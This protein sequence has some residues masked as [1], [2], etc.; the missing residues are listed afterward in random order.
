MQKQ[1]FVQ[2]NGQEVQQS[3]L[4]LLGENSALADDRTL[5]G[6]LRLFPY[7]GGVT[8]KA[9]VPVDFA[10]LVSPAVGVGSVF[11]SP[12]LAVIGSRSD[13]AGDVLKNYQDIRSAWLLGGLPFGA[14]QQLAHASNA[15]GNPRWDLILAQVTVDPNDTSVTRYVKDP[16]SLQPVPQTLPVTKKTNVVVVITPGT[17]AASPTKPAAPADVGN[18][19]FIPIAYVRIPNGFNGTSTTTINDIE[20]CGPVV[21]ASQA[22]GLSGILPANSCFKPTGAMLAAGGRDPWAASGNRPRAYLPPSMTGGAQRFIPLQFTDAPN[23]LANG[24]IVDD[25]IDWR[26]RLFRWQACVGSGIRF[27]WDPTLATTPC[28]STL[29]GGTLSHQQGMGQSFVSEGVASQCPVAQINGT[30]QSPVQ[31]RTDQVPANTVV[32]LY[33]DQSDG[34]LKLAL[35]GA[36]PAACVLFWIDAT[37]PFFN[38]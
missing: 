13:S 2:N 28:P 14:G 27:A 36:A 9:V 8:A 25:S 21:T 10:P 12:F 22:M 32:Q 17:P 5:Q 3:D 26:N 34:K 19:Y 23:N 30:A 31:H 24:D 29:Q 20:E 4:N 6:I 1:Y 16:V 15:S 38:H 18:I 35:S 11:V 7:A 37:A 33:V